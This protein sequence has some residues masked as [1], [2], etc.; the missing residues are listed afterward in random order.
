[1]CQYFFQDFPSL[2]ESPSVSH[3][4]KVLIV[5]VEI[6]AVIIPQEPDTVPVGIEFC[7]KGRHLLTFAKGV[8]QKPECVFQCFH[9]LVRNCLPLLHLSGKC[10]LDKSKLLVPSGAFC[11]RFGQLP[12]L[13]IGF[14][15][16]ITEVP[17]FPGSGQKPAFFF[18][19]SARSLQS[20]LKM[21]SS[22]Y[23]FNSANSRSV[24][25]LPPVRPEILGKLSV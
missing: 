17:V 5:L 6:R 20:L 7:Q 11:R 21:C 14:Q 13:L 2:S 25:H 1:M 24:W 4:T 3:Q 10:F 12:P 22:L 16:V 8:L 18:R 15:P 19:S 23:T 9:R